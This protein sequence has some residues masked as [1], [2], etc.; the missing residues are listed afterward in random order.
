MTDTADNSDYNAINTAY[1]RKRCGK[2]R[3]KKEEEIKQMTPKEKDR[4][5]CTLC[6]GVAVNIGGE[7]LNRNYNHPECRK[8]TKV[9]VRY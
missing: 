2:A 6:R 3:I 5:F 8:C 7:E 9:Y 4:Y 1:N